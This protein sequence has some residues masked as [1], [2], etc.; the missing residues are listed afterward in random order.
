M[1]PSVNGWQF[2]NQLTRDPALVH[3][4]VI[5]ATGLGIAIKEWAA[6]LGAAGLLRKPF[7]AVQLVLEVERFL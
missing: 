6:S 7:D 1:L 4:P 5:T 2:L 3:V